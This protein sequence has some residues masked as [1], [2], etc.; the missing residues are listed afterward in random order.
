MII[1]LLLLIPKPIFLH[2][3]KL[4]KAVFTH[5]YHVRIFSIISHGHTLRESIKFRS[6]LV[7]LRLCFV[8]S[9]L[10]LSWLLPRHWTSCTVS[11]AAHFVVLPSSRCICTKSTVIISS[12]TTWEGQVVACDDRALWLS[13]LVVSRFNNC[14]CP[15]S[16]S[17]V[18]PSIRVSVLVLLQLWIFQLQQ[19]L[20]FLC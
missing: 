16:Q 12:R 4:I 9:K 1:K 6:R 18:P 8:V 15:T 17:Q 20:L 2:N 11:L 13:R 5:G 3:A 19:K 14:Q 10:L 7:V